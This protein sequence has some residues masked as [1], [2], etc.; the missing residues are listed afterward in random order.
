[1]KSVETRFYC[2]LAFH[3][4]NHQKGINNTN[5][6]SNE[7]LLKETYD[8][9]KPQSIPTGKTPSSSTPSPSLPSS[10]LLIIL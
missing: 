3:L 2:Y 9:K 8:T 4:F 10:S 1:M 6:K 5:L 7:M